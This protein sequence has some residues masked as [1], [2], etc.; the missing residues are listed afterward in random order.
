[1][2]SI[3]D[4]SEYLLWAEKNMKELEN[5]LL[6]KDYD[7]EK[8]QYKAAAIKHSVDKC[9]IWVDEERAKQAQ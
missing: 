4:W 5:M 7:L 9:L 1:M 2:N 8:M 3:N 6:H